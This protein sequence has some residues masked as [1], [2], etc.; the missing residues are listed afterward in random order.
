MWLPNRNL[1]MSRMS[2]LLPAAASSL[3][4]VLLVSLGQPQT[5]EGHA[6]LINPS[7]RPWQDYL[8]HY[9]Y[10][11]HA[12]NAGGVYV[13]MLLYCIFPCVPCGLLQNKRAMYQA[14]K[15]GSCSESLQME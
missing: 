4:A 5:A 2:S 13:H 14:A 7:S 6:V 1:E 3:L 8:R 11:P 12:V 15:C 9:N 10:N